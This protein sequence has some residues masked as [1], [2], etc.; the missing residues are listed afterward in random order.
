MLKTTKG[1]LRFR[2]Y[3]PQGG[4]AGGSG[5]VS[6]AVFANKLATLVRALRAADTAVNG[7]P[8]HDYTIAKLQTSDPT[9]LLREVPAPRFAGMFT[10]SSGI[11]AFSDCVEA[12][13]IGSPKV[14][15]YGKCAAYIE[16]LA[17]PSRKGLAYAAIWPNDENE[18]NAIRLDS[19][20]SARARH[21]TAPTTPSDF[22]MDQAE[23]WFK[24]AAFG[25]FEG[26]LEFVDA[27]GALPQVK[28]TLSAGGKVI[29]CICR[30]EDLETIG[31]SLKKRVRISGRAIYDGT[32]GLPIRVEATEIA[33]VSSGSDFSKWRG[34]F[35]PFEVQEWGDDCP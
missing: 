17:R 34:A 31:A 2:A 9:A 28:L 10:P 18:E 16:S 8:A 3:G 24:G 1:L 29:D 4:A 12:V 6:A 27:R 35:E 33:P 20:L 13:K 30:A 11:G 32:Q 14:K 22:G 19:F 7:A 15:E 25:S 23:P 21:V 26:Y 5:E